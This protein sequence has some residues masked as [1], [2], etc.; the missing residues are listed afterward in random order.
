VVSAAISPHPDLPTLLDTGGRQTEFSS[1]AV[2]GSAG[3]A[4]ERLGGG[5]S[6]AD[7]LGARAGAAT[8]VVA[9]R[10]LHVPSLAVRTAMHEPRGLV[11]M[12]VLRGTVLAVAADPGRPVLWQIP[13]ADSEAARL[14][15]P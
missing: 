2:P 13:A 10:E 11:G 3:G 9:G 14:S 15:L 6:G 1:D 4:S 7:V 8:L 5:V 12:D